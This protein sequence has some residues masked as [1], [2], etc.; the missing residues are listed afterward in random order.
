MNI[1]KTQNDDN[2]IIKIQLGKED[3][4]S[5][6]ENVLKDYQKK[7]VIDGFRKGKTPMGIVKKIYGKAVLVEEI[8]KVLGEA[9]NNYIKENDLQILG[10]PLPSETEQKELDLN[11]ENFEFMTLLFL[12]R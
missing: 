3:Y 9:L 11:D 2:A 5:R 4:A 12:P 8:N 6:V 7:V 10:E 1:T